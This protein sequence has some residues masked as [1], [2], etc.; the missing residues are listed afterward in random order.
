MSYFEE[1]GWD[2]GIFILYGLLRPPFCFVPVLSHTSFAA[3]TNKPPNDE[4]ATTGTR[5]KQTALH[6]RKLLA[7]KGDQKAPFPNRRQP[8][9]HNH[10]PERRGMSTATSLTTPAQGAGKAPEQAARTA[11]PSC[12]TRTPQPWQGLVCSPPLR[13]T[14]LP[15]SGRE[16]RSRPH[17]KHSQ[18]NKE[19]FAVGN[20]RHSPL[21]APGESLHTSRPSSARASPADTGSV[22]LHPTPV[23]PCRTSSVSEC[24]IRGLSSTVLCSERMTY[25]DA[26]ILGE[27]GGECSGFKYGCACGHTLTRHN[28]GQPSCPHLA[29]CCS[30]RKEQDR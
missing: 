19:E 4:Y 23:A 13:A 27:L 29:S 30:R 3:L 24:L 11:G 20:S 25:Q 5:A 12:N 16:Q 15:Q 21:P 6:Q 9:E 28:E 22:P 17:P 18:H 14:N 2:P 1:K 10:E 8:A 26:A 7:G